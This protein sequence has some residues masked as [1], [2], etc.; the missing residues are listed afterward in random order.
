M[1]FSI[2]HLIMNQCQCNGCSVD[3]FNDGDLY[4]FES[5]VTFTSPA[6]GLDDDITITIKNQDTCSIEDADDV[7]FNCDNFT[8]PH[9]TET[10]FEGLYLISLS[11]SNT[12]LE[13]SDVLLNLAGD[14]TGCREGSGYNEDTNSC[15]LCLDGTFNLRNDLSPCISCDGLD[16]V[17][18]DGSN[19]ITVA[20]RYWVSG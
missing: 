4:P 11:S 2:W 16:G 14:I 8:L 7:M 13:S 1:N 19:I 6:L 17:E 5:K 20:H 3:D 9:V 10:Y 18:C 12:Y 15:S